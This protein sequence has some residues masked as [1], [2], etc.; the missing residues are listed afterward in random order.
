MADDLII[1]YFQRDLTEAEDQALSGLLASSE[2]EAFRF[3]R[4]AEAAYAHYGLPDPRWPGEGPG[5]SG[6]A[7]TKPHLW[8]IVLGI[9]LLIS[10]WGWWS[11]RGVADAIGYIPGPKAVAGTGSLG[12]A[13]RLHPE[14][15]GRSIPFGGAVDAKDQGQDVVPGDVPGSVERST[16]PLVTSPRDPSPPPGNAKSEGDPHPNL[17]VLVRQKRSG[18]VT[19]QVLS[20]EGIPV[21]LLYEGN[22][23]PGSWT[24][25]WNGDLEQGKKAPPG[26][27][28][29]QVHS[30]GA[31]LT[32]RVLIK[33]N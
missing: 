11:H 15:Q 4:H 21:V 26:T 10:G 7:W 20:P 25:D 27:Y 19:V 33:E 18:P 12:M 8:G 31:T 16:G 3:F 29:I 13:P 17:E 30:G 22:L 28:R 6:K 1:H 32:R 5:G 9:G 14:T 23:Q 2:E 24:F